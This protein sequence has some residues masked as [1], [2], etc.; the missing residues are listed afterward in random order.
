MGNRALPRYSER[1][2]LLFNLQ[3]L[4]IL[5]KKGNLERHYNALHCNKY[6]AGF[7]P[8]TEI[9]ELKLKNL[10]RNE[11]LNN[12]LRQNQSHFLTMQP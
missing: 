2:A 8:K 6:D 4:S 1:Q 3:R 9:R 5:A 12:S 10:N 11:L 7:P